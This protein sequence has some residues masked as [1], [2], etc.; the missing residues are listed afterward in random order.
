MKI[1][2]E[3]ITGAPWKK[4]EQA[5]H[6]AHLCQEGIELIIKA[7]NNNNRFVRVRAY[8]ILEKIK[9]P[10]IIIQLTQFREQHYLINFDGI[11]QYKHRY[12]SSY[13]RFYPDYT[14]ITTS[15]TDAHEKVVT[16]FNKENHD[17]YNDIYLIEKGGGKISFF[18]NCN[19]EAINYNAFVRN[20]NT[21]N[22]CWFKRI[23]GTNGSNIYQYIKLS[24]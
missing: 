17:I 9:V 18:S 12:Y 1:L 2:I 22:V 19:D 3:I 8:E 15:T 13:L 20:D 6:E 10:E 21:I 4:S 14:V 7:L 11:Y 5:V 23:D 16:W 24:S